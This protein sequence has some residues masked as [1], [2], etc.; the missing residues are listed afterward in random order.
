[1]ENASQELQQEFNDARHKTV[2]DEI[3]V[4]GYGKLPVR[5]IIKRIS[6]EFDKAKKEL[7][8]GNYTNVNHQFGLN[9]VMS[10]FITALKTHYTLDDEK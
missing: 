5:S 7:E 9:G 4:S 1:M 10:T 8:T 6:D 2:D 3:I